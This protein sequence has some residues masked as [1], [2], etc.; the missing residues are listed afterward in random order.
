MIQ[1]DAAV[2]AAAVAAAAD[3]GWCLVLVLLVLVR[4]MKL[5]SLLHLFYTHACTRVKRAR[6]STIG[7]DTHFNYITYH[8]IRG[9]SYR[10]GI[11]IKSNRHHIL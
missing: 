4:F 10:L 3:D 8:P 6:N 2:A 11:Q 9:L 5:P 7:H 1:N